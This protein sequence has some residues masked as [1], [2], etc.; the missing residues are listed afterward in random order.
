MKDAIGQAIVV[1]AIVWKNH[2]HVQSSSLLQ[3]RS[4]TPVCGEMFSVKESLAIICPRLT[5]YSNTGFFYL[6]IKLVFL[7]IMISR[8]IA[9]GIKTHKNH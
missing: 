1:A 9:L 8:K 4:L 3:L 5:G 2:L 6:A 7:V